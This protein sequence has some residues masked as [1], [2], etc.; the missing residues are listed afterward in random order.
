MATTVKLRKVGN[1]IGLTLPREELARLQVSEG[2]ELYVTTDSQGIHLQPFD[3]LFER[4]MKLFERSNAKFR[5][6][7]RELAK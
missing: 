4:K 1:S 6:A 5:N 7:L 3:P 2:D